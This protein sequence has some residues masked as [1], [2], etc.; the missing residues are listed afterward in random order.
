MYVC[1]HVVALNVH[2]DCTLY[3]QILMTCTTSF[4]VSRELR[5]EVASFVVNCTQP[6]ANLLQVCK[7][8]AV[9]A[10]VHLYLLMVDQDIG[11]SL[12]LD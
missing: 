9:V 10:T 5:S 6:A 3:Q 2:C 1:T 7:L 12:A 8:T 4:D 11:T